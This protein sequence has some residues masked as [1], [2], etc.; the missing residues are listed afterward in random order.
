MAAPE[1]LPR[2]AIIGAGVTGLLL[3]QGLQKVPKHGYTVTV[4]EKQPEQTAYAREWTMILHWA[5]PI[6]SKMLPDDLVPDIHTAFGDPFHPY[7]PVEEIPFYNGGTGELM[8]KIPTEGCRRMSRTRL[9]KLCARGVDV[10]WGVKVVDMEVVGED[11][12]VKVYLQGA[13]GGGCEE[14]DVV[15]GADG[16][17]SFVRRW[18]F[19]EKREVADATNSTV[20]IA[21]GLA[22][23]P[24]TKLAER[25]RE[26]S[27][28]CLVATMPGRTFVCAAQDVVDPDDASTWTFHTAFMWK[29][30]TPIE[31]PITGDEASELVKRRAIEANLAEPFRSAIL[32]AP[33]DATFFV[34]QLKYWVTVP[35]DGR[36][37]RVTLAGDAAHALLPA[38]GQGL[39]QALADVD[40]LL[41]LFVDIK[42]SKLH[43]KDAI[44]RYEQ[45]VFERG[46]KAALGSLEDAK[47]FMSTEG[48]ET[49]MGRTAKEGF[50]RIQND[51]V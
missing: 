25:L 36:G 49:G 30:I 31:V 11:G 8:M 48:F 27:K 50:K 18:L 45:D 33:R 6:I 16:S 32:E 2:V 46:R 39:N 19:D 47:D 17:G 9:R 14:V 10:R 51:N 35:W 3:A 23:Y 5:L 1:N 24:D 28:V 13:E 12:P 38:R 42:S 43:L 41:S 7:K 26:G 21:N 34:S 37:G 20:A 15:I 44:G 4:Y 22:R 29:E 40:A